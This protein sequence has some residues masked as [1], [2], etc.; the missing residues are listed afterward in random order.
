MSSLSDYI[1]SYLKL[2]FDTAQD[3]WVEVCRRELAERFRCAPSQINYVLSTR[4]T[5]E[6][7]YLVETRRGGGG[8]VRIFR[9]ARRPRS[10]AAEMVR[11]S[12]GE[13]IDREAA[14]G[15]IAKLLEMGALDVQDAACIRA[16][17]FGQERENE[18]ELERVVRA[19]V[20]RAT[21]L[22]MLTQ[23]PSA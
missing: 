8:Y 6:R 22:F 18:L 14:E 2:L 10:G 15:L 19:R 9:L 4:F 16:A 23:P 12:V 20:L 17:V 7:G 5:L 13:A 11:D 1:E 3:E 21:L